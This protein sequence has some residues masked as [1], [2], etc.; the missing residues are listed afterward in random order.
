MALP[1]YFQAIEN[2]LDKYFSDNDEIVVFDEIKSPD[3]HLD[4]YWVKPNENR[5]FHILLTNGVSSKP[6]ETPNKDFSPYVELAILL[7]MEWELENI[8]WKRPEN[9]WPI[10]LLKGIGRYPHQNNICHPDNRIKH[11]F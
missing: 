2:H 3:F 1:E 4:V 5:N 10:S 7:P 8:E 9:Y 6:M 11:Y